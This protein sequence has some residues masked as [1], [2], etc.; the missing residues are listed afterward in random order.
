VDLRHGLATA[1]RRLPIAMRTV[2]VLRYWEGLPEAEVAAEIGCS[3]GTVKSQASRGLVRLRELVGPWA[4]PERDLD[5]ASD[6][7]A[8]RAGDRAAGHRPGRVPHH[9][10]LT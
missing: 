2:L 5:H 10:P 7:A 3:V 9:L 1:L 8:D 6:R 4:G